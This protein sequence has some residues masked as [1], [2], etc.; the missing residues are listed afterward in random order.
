MSVVTLFSKPSCVQ[1][2]ASVRTLDK[3]GIDY[4]VLDITE[5]LEVYAYLTDVL[6]S[7]QAPVLVVSDKSYGSVEEFSSEDVI[8]K[9]SWTGFNPDKIKEYA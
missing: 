3:A 7:Q 1:C 8:I 6:K 9:D 5:N 2:N 4:E